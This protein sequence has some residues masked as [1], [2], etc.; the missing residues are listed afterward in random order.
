MEP[1]LRAVGLL[2]KLLALVVMPLITLCNRLRYAPIRV[3]PPD[4][5]LLRLSVVELAERIRS[6]RVTAVQAVQAYVT[7]CRLVNGLLNA[8]VED[9]YEEALVE[10]ARMDTMIG[11]MK[12]RDLMSRYP[13]CG[14][15]FTVKESCSLKGM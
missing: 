8:V 15:P 3:P 9:R 6:K 14:V 10:A 2:L 12:Q 1:L 5:E 4:D 13:L 7:R 11:A